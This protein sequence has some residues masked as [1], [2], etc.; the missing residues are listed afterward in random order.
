[1]SCIDR[2]PRSNLRAMFLGS[3]QR[4]VAFAVL[5]FLA[6]LPSQ[7]AAQ[8]ASDSTDIA[9]FEKKIRPVFVEHCYKCHSA[10]AEKLKGGLRL[11]GRELLL[12]GGD[13]GPALVPGEPDKSLLIKAIRYTDPDLK[14][15]PKD[16]KLSDAQIADITAW[17]A[18]GAPMPSAT[19]ALVRKYDFSSARTNWAFRKPIDPPIPVFKSTG[20]IKSP[21]DNFLLAKIQDAGLKP[22]PLADKRTLLRRA[23]YDL[24]GLPPTPE[25]A[26]T[27]LKDNSTNAFARLVDRLLA[28]PRYGEKWARHWLDVVRYTDSADSRGI[29]GEGD[30][31]EAWRYRDWVVNAFNGDMPYDQFVMQQIAGDILATNTPGKLDTNALIATSVYA[32]G[33]WG[34][35]DADKE[36]MLTDIVDDQIDLTGRGFL[37]VTLACARCHDH[38][39]DPIPTSDYYGLAG[40]FFSSHILPNPGIKTAGSPPLRIPLATST[41][42]TARKAKE[43][44]ATQLEKEIASKSAVTLLT[45]AER[46]AQNQPTLAALHPSDGTDLPNAVA[47]SGDAAINFITIT[48]PARSVAIHPSPEKNA[49]AIWQSPISGEVEISGRI[50]DADDKCGNGIE[51][52]LFRGTNSIQSGKFDNG[53]KATLKT[54]NISVKA[55]ELITLAVLPRGKD[56]SCDTTVIELQIRERGGERAWRLPEDVVADLPA[57]ANAG[58]WHFVA[59]AGTPPSALQTS[60][61]NEERQKLDSLR[62]ELAAL[63]KELERK[64]SVTHGLQEGGTPQSAYVGFHDSHILV[65]GKYDRQDD[66]VPRHFPRVLGGDAQPRIGAN[67]SGRLE[68]AKWIAS[69]ENPLT[70][71]VM[72]NRIWQQHFGEG[73]VRTPNNFG[74][75]GTPPT[76]P[77]LLDWLAHRFV[78]SGWSIKAMHRLMMNSAAYQAASI[79][80]R[81]SRVE[82][83]SDPENLWLARMNR[84]RL[85]AEE[86]RDALLFVSGQIDFTT[87]GAAIND[88]NTKRRTLYVMT[89]RSDK[90][91]YRS[92]F[93]APDAQT[94]AEKRIDSTVA[95]QA[96]FLLNSPFAL[97]QAKAL[98]ERVFKR[99][100]KDNSE[101][102]KWLYVLLYGREPKTKELEIGL[103]TIVDDQNHEAAWERYCQVLLCANEFVFVD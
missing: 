35:G 78:E 2:A 41:E 15:P 8:N 86:I 69:K 72:V 75:L 83:R 90:S 25:E 99:E 63:R 34:G 17:V 96:L 1:M 13:T 60:L 11:D 93:D 24:T 7:S 64:I 59:Y 12:K 19:N 74:K 76:H 49:A 88:L 27:F 73:I 102:I 91:N 68:L 62:K 100:A 61:S 3:I 9:F 95:P 103:K 57:R 14:M 16:K 47:N 65:R 82:S 70:A 44:R 94:I 84:R 31:S 54:T 46:G 4:L 52:A 22:T 56:H 43:Q 77:E 32:I 40:I 79:E 80:G 20:K 39:F 26:D 51:W 87:R 67:E 36:K 6:S 71:R 101:R 33:E 66:I 18:S 81:E 5:C 45:R 38:K 89:I 98:A 23:T 28:S 55:D 97:A 10:E 85:E 92:L 58:A 37:G 29:G 53:G 48:L 30:F 42:L 50:A 21:I